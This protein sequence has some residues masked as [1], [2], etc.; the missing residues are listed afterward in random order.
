MIDKEEMIVESHKSLGDPKGSLRDVAMAGGRKESRM[1]ILAP[2]PHFP[3]SKFLTVTTMI[4][5]IPDGEKTFTIDKVFMFDIFPAPVVEIIVAY[6]EGVCS[7]DEESA[8]L[9]M[10]RFMD[11]VFRLWLTYGYRLNLATKICFA[12]IAGMFLWDSPIAFIIACVCSTIISIS[13]FTQ[14]YHIFFY[15][16]KGVRQQKLWRSLYPLRIRAFCQLRGLLQTSI[17]GHHYDPANNAFFCGQ[18]KQSDRD[19]LYNLPYIM[20]VL[21]SFF[22]RASWCWVLT[23]FL[24]TK[25][26]GIETTQN[27]LALWT[28]PLLVFPTPLL[29]MFSPMEEHVLLGKKDEVRNVGY[30][31]LMYML[32]AC[33]WVLGIFSSPWLYLI[34]IAFWYAALCILRFWYL[35]IE[36]TFWIAVCLLYHLDVFGAV[37]SEKGW[38]AVSTLAIIVLAFYIITPL[39]DSLLVCREETQM[40]ILAKDMS[41]TL[42]RSK[43]FQDNYKKEYRAHI[44]KKKSNKK[45]ETSI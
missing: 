23:L 26:F 22:I 24:A 11:S 36:S 4:K 38:S 12:A 41:R 40:S 42:I 9:Q 45:N 1:S 21:W 28:L 3:S 44:R 18:K 34:G 39:W 30:I 43:T 25:V 15:W 27:D 37:S 16:A 33:I 13:N 14:I 2:V 5:S 6:S 32:Y 29:C 17:I 20:L 7:H 10:A 35:T 31:G 19:N 8:S